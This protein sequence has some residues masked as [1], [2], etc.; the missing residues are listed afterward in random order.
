VVAKL[1]RQRH[2]AYG[3]FDV[4]EEIAVQGHLDFVH[5]LCASSKRSVASHRNVSRWC[6][7]GHFAD[8]AIGA[9]QR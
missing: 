1:A 6:G 7:V 9:Q 4:A 5:L 2:A 8:D 3:G